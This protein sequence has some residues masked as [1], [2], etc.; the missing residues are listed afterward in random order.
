M[1]AQP[2]SFRQAHTNLNFCHEDLLNVWSG[3]WNIRWVAQAR[4]D[5]SH[6]GLMDKASIMKAMPTRM[7]YQ[8]WT[9]IHRQRHASVTDSAA[10]GVDQVKGN[11]K[12]N[13]KLL[14]SAEFQTPT[15]FAQLVHTYHNQPSC[16][17]TPAGPVEWNQP[18]QEICDLGWTIPIICILAK[19][20]WQA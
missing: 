9:T 18:T 7:T 5:T 11:V 2:P 10:I 14:H 4:T 13:W 15:V 16:S 3:C 20:N 1:H 17:P 19:I 8:R 6:E 12:S